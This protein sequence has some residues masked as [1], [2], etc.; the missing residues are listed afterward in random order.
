MT[1]KLESK[2]SVE[3]VWN[4][5]QVRIQNR[6]SQVLQQQI[7]PNRNSFLEVLYNN[8]LVIAD[9]L[10][11]SL[12]DKLFCYQFFKAKAPEFTEKYLPKTVGLNEYAKKVA[13]LVKNKEEMVEI[14]KKDFPQGCIIKPT[15]EINSDGI[16]ILFSMEDVVAKIFAAIN[17][18]NTE[19]YW[20]A[21]LEK[22]VSG[23]TYMIQESV[24]MDRSCEFRV[25]T[26]ESFVVPKATSC[27]WDHFYDR[28]IFAELE[29]DLQSAFNE[30]DGEILS[31]QAWGLDVFYDGKDIK[32]VDLNT[33]R[34]HKRQWSGDMVVPDVLGAYTRFL[35]NNYGYEFL[36]EAGE[37]LRA[38]QANKR[39]WMKKFGQETIAH[40]QELK[41]QDIEA[42]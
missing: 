20:S 17:S 41:N 30:I 23:E 21:L 38:D 16:S 5:R 9:E 8:E 24:A 25:H 28:K 12:S 32:I 19:P 40:Y 36:G 14:L 26:L 11:L 22:V 10:S 6:P 18:D 33:N 42:V 15:T 37:Q 39:Q 13:A 27:R 2:V 34:G 29:K 35:E 4:K 3:A 1:Q 7:L 31:G